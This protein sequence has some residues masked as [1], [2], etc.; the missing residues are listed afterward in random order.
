MQSFLIA[1]NE[2]W[3][4]CMDTQADSSLS[5]TYVEV[6]NRLMVGYML[7]Y[8]FQVVVLLTFF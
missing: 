7:K 8:P 3:L 4:D 5:W 6:C 2:D 1:D